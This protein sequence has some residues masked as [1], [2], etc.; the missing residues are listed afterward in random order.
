MSEIMSEM[1][2]F[3]STC[4]LSRAFLRLWSGNKQTRLVGHK[5]VGI[6]KFIQSD[7]TFNCFELDLAISTFIVS[8]IVHS[9]KKK[10]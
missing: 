6:V 8:I 10:N 1:T 5:R 7:L 3:K 4:T 9:S 2:S